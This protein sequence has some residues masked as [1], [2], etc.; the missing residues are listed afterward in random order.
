M[1]HFI[2]TC[3]LIAISALAGCAA[4]KNGTPEHTAIQ[5]TINGVGA[6]L[7]GKP[8]ATPN[9]PATTSL[10]AQGGQMVLINGINI[11]VA[12]PRPS[13]AR[14]Q[15]KR[16]SETQLNRFFESHPIR[17]PGD[18]WPRIGI[19]LDDYSESLLSDSNLKHT[20]QLSGSMVA[21]VARPLE[22]IKFTAVVWMSEKQ[23]Q[24]IDG[25]VH[26]NLDIKS[27]ESVLSTGALRMYRTVMAP[28]SI[29]SEQ[30]RSLGPRVPSKLLPDTTQDDLTLYSN[31]QHLF[32]SIF[33]QMGYRGPLDG[34]QRMWF[35]N[36]AEP[37]K[38]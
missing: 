23:S 37:G 16:I 12:G 30:L 18:Y 4:P 8:A 2:Q 22:C 21:N 13:D 10:Q 14:W 19:R 25:V 6:L 31:G 29:S 24:R 36:L 1:K 5:N 38:R 17:R 33:T 28:I 9:T 26:C 32:S 7:G 3:A 34:D 20:N 11:M 15:G 35:V 27:G